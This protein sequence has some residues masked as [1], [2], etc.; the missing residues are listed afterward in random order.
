M[1]LSEKKSLALVLSGGG[2]KA[3]AFHVGVCLALKEK[4]FRFAGGSQKEVQDCFAEDKMTFKTYVGSSAGAVISATLAAGYS[5]EALV[6]AYTKGQDLEEELSSKQSTAY[7]RLLAPLSYG[8][9]FS[10]NFSTESPYKMLKILFKKRPAITGGLEVFLK[11]GFKLGG[12]FSTKNIEKY[13]REKVCTNN[14]FDLLG[15]NLSIITTALNQPC[16]IIFQA[17]SSNE[18]KK[19]ENVE[20]AHFAKISEAVAASASLPPLF[21]PY[22]LKDEKD[23]TIYLYDG[24]IRDTLSTHVAEDMGADLIVASYSMQPYQYNKEMGSLHEYGMPVILEQAMY[25]C[26]QQKIDSTRQHRRAVKKLFQNFKD[27]FNKAHI[28]KEQQDKIMEILNSYF[29]C[30]LNTEYIYIHPQAEDYDMFFSDHFSLN[31]KILS[32]IVKIGFKTA[33]NTLDNFSI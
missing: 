15:V 9:I 16:K 22:A 19:S 13:L 26:L 14:D 27:Y 5:L 4:G 25:Q 8:D 23:Q 24:D 28:K 20:Y 10:L 30:S 29:S 3:A 2:V 1:H 31:P 17:S 32:K 11:K 6:Q 18:R 21:V 7:E 33:M 12:L